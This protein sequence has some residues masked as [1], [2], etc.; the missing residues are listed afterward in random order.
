MAAT[1]AKNWKQALRNEG[2]TSD[3]V[4]FYPVAFEHADAEK[5]LKF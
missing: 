1:I 5:A 3:E 4:K 2:V